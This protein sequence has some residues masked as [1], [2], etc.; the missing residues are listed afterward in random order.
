MDRVQ[1]VLEH[2][3]IKGMKWGIRRPGGSSSTS[4]G[5]ESSSDAT[6]AHEYASKAKTGGLHTLSNQELQHLVTRQGLESQYKRLQG[7]SRTDA[8]AKVAK[9]ILLNAGKQHLTKLAVEG[10]ANATKAALKKK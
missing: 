2:H 7:N 9:E 3:G 8:G 4:S 10:L 5:H 6:K 1:Q